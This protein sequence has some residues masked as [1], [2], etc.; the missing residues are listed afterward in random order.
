MNTGELRS[1]ILVRTGKSTTSGWITDTFLNDFLTQAHRWAAGFK[2]WPFTEGRVS[3]TYATGSGAG[4]DEYTFEGYKANSFRIMTVGNERLRKLNFDD[5]L[6]LKDKT[7]AVTDKVFSDF[8]NIIYINQQASLGGTLVAYGQYVPA[9]FD[10]TATDEETVFS[11]IAEDGSQ[12][13]I[14]EAIS[15]V[16]KRDG[17][18][19]QAQE[20]H[21]LAKTLLEELWQRV[22]DEKHAYQTHANRGGMYKRIDVIGK[23]YYEDLSEDQF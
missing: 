1:Q 21:L 15:Y 18:I 4:S 23:G 13:V 5:Y 2:P 14:E 16:Y 11:N 7:P 10:S 17:K 9:K 3:T 12:A 6:I 20:Q 8:A 22:Q 19:V